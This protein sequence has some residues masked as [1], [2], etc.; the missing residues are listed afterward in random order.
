MPPN[1]PSLTDD[2][3]TPEQIIEQDREIL[4]RLA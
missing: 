1:T 4:D 3:P 2:L